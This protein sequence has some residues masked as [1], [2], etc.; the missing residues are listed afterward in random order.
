MADDPQ[1]QQRSG[2]SRINLRDGA[3]VDHWTRKLG[4]SAE[5]LAKVVEVAG[6]RASDV[7]QYLAQEGR[8]ATSE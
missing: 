6:D 4:V 3:D 5:E 2:D 1:A 8:P 7:E